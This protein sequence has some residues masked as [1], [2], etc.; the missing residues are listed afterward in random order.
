MLFN[1]NSVVISPV[2]LMRKTAHDKLDKA[3]HLITS[4]KA[5]V[6]KCKLGGE[7]NSDLHGLR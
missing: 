5:F 7:L 1:A 2:P 4:V 6:P 3:P